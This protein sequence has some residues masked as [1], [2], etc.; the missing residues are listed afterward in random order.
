MHLTRNKQEKC[1]M[2]R[3]RRQNKLYQKNF[4]LKQYRTWKAAETAAQKWVKKILPSLPPAIPIKG[5]MTKRNTSGVVGVRLIESVRKKNGKQYH[6]WRWIA[7]W[8]GCPYSGGIGWS[9]NKY[10]DEPAFVRAYLARMLSTIDRARIEREFTRIR[11]LNKLQKILDRK[12][13]EVV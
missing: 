10:G 3:I 4:T 2:A 11:G 8:T 1:I 9:V 13:I 7:F 6:D 5:R 12:L